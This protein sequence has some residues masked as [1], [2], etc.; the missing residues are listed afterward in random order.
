[1]TIEEKIKKIIEIKKKIEDLDKEDKFIRDSIKEEM[2]SS[3]KEKIEF[4]D[5]KIFF[6][7]RK[8]IK[9]NRSIEEVI[10]DLKEKELNEYVVVKEELSPLFEKGIKEGIIS[11][12][13]AIIE[14]D[15]SLTLKL[16]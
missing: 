13:N 11:Y 15:K 9:Y 4:E 12:D 8:K 2:L 14:E 1:M 16:C 6:T 3:S 5:A 10:S 7:S